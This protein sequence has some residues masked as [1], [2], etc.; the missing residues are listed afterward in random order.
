MKRLLRPCCLAWL[1]LAVGGSIS[2]QL[3]TARLLT[4]F[5]PG[6]KAGSQF[7]VVATGL[8]LDEA[9]RLYFDQ[10]GISA[11]PK[12]E[13]SAESKTFLL[14]IAANVPPGV[15]EAR[16]VGRNGISNPR[17]FPVGTLPEIT[18]PITNDSPANAAPLLLE[19]TVNGRCVAD[20]AQYFRFAARARQRILIT[21]ATK[22]IDSR[23]EPGL[24]LY[25]TTGR[26][27]ERS[28]REGLLDFTCPADDTYLL[29][30][31]DSIFRG[32]GE[33]FYR[34]SAGTGPHLDFIFPPSGLAGTK[35]KFLV[36][37]R[38][39]PGGSAIKDL[40]VDGKPLEQLEVEIEMPRSPMSQPQLC[41]ALQ[42][43]QL[44]LDTFEYR[45][46]TSR[47]FSY[48][49]RIGF[50][51]GP[52]MPAPP[53]SEPT[54][55][56]Q[57]LSLPCE[58]VGQFQPRGGWNRA[59]F[60][61]RKGDV[62]RVETFS[63]RLG[64]AT[65][66]LVVIQRVTK[67]DQGEER[68]SDVQEFYGADSSAGGVE[69]NTATRDPVGRFEAPEN[70]TYRIQVRDLFN[71]AQT[72]AR[73]V[74]RVSLRKETPDFRLLVAA[75]PPASS[76]KDAREA[77]LWTPFL[78]RGETQPIKVLALRRDQFNGEIK[79]T[80]EGLPAGIS[81]D[82]AKIEKDK[83]SAWIMLTAN[84]S[85]AGWMGPV[86][87]LGTASIGETE[88]VRVARG[89]T[90]KWTVADYNT[91]AVQSRLTGDFVVAVTSLESA[92][93]SVEANEDKVWE[94]S[95]AGKLKIPIRVVRRDNF[96]A[97]LKL[98]AGG[99]AAL[100]KL[101][102]I[103]VDGKATS[104]MV[105]LDLTEHA[106]PPGTYDFHL[107]TQATAKYRQNPEAAKAAAAAAQ[108]AEKSVAELTVALKTT[109]E[110]RLAAV[111]AAEEAETKTQAQ[112]AALSA[113]DQAAK[114][115]AAVAKE[116]TEKLVAANSAL[117]AKPDDDELRAAKEE[118]AKAAEAAAVKSKPLLEARS[119]AET[120]AAEAANL[121][122]S[123]AAT[124]RAAKEAE[125][126]TPAKL[127]AAEAIKESATK[128]AKTTAETAEPREVTIT[129]YSAPIHLKV[130]PAPIAQK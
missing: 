53:P 122:K 70:G 5:P 26:E 88:V 64:L 7:E 45:L 4:I 83:N 16:V 125:A 46:N 73:A 119:K 20:A 92:P 47:G 99:L 44:A 127:K 40:T 60:D 126:E 105:E 85:A 2:A 55:P 79:L 50:A 100:E 130:T 3:P 24:I 68:V 18:A 36:Y 93:I 102:E 62:F 128:L 63:Q 25:D 117:E 94:T 114:Q 54:G 35:G 78:R 23:M 81:A 95:V 106:V 84:E 34:L 67:N 22:E 17:A 39:L 90:V 12:G 69:Y 32:G 65:D 123:A 82:S 74:F 31:H 1:W 27:L 21:C 15:Y 13:D 6:G 33:Y 97:N 28:R 115:A 76:N 103:E 87:V 96:G 120:L 30:V 52:V 77:V 43:A 112:A 104:A 48:A 98:K 14:G 8:D 121:A 37:G 71:G 11:E 80:I 108:Q 19:T 89:G 113:A 75:Q 59:V 66:P 111:R 51:S 9:S 109:A 58:W 56:E 101:K 10:A 38:N 49:V 42:P 72:D 110:A 57:R 41:A 116:A 124:L 86:K 91:E 118:A 29:K 107:Q 61:A 129:V